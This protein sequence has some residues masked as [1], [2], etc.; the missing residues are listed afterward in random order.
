MSEDEPEL[1]GPKG[2][3]SRFKMHYV[4]L[5]ILVLAGATIQVPFNTVVFDSLG[6]CD[7]TVNNEFKPRRPGYYQFVGSANF[8]QG[9]AAAEDYVEIWGGFPIH[10]VQAHHY[11][12][13]GW[14]AA[15]QVCAL[16]YVR[17]ADYVRLYFTNGGVNNGN[18]QGGILGT[19]FLMGHRVS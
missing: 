1:E 6:E 15:L 16:L 19:T 11:V 13:G 9:A 18:L 10:Q 14:S 3:R 12:V 7:V 5:P 2:F 8:I 4:G 17:P